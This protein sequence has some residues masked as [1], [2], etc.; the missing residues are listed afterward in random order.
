VY[1][2]QKCYISIHLDMAAVERLKLGIDACVVREAILF[3]VRGITRSAVLRALKEGDVLVKKGD[4]S[5][6]RVYVTDNA[7][8]KLSTSPYFTM[9]LLK[10]ALPKVIVQGIPTV[11]RAV[12]SEVE[13]SSPPKYNL[14]IEGYG[15]REVMGSPGI[16]GYSTTT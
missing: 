11:N 5:K 2:L 15:L 12:I 3:G 16:N 10:A 4:P 14:L 1:D 8:T 7:A 6:L 9:Q 13:G